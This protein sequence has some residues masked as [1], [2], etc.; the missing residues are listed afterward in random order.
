MTTRE[1]YIARDGKEFD[2]EVECTKYELE[3]TKNEEN[4]K[5]V[6]TLKNG[7]KLTGDDIKEFFRAMSCNDCPLS[8]QCRAMKGKIRMSTPDT[9][10]LFVR[11]SI[12][13]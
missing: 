4:Q 8:A 2:S 5:K 9:F 10:C 7:K 1:V 11:N 13:N 3:L 12:V 6:F